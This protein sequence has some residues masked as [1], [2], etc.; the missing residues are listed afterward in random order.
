[1]RKEDWTLLEDCSEW[2]ALGR[3]SKA[4]YRFRKTNY[5]LH[6][7]VFDSSILIEKKDPFPWV[8]TI[9][10]MLNSDSLSNE[11]KE[12]AAYYIHLDTDNLSIISTES[13][14]EILNTIHGSI[15]EWE[16]VVK[17]RKEKELLDD[18]LGKVAADRILGQREMR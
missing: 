1:M 13:T 5:Y 16:S 9:E 17:A 7:L 10:Y 12:F 11:D 6:I 2:R 4:I 18:I 15:E 14:K 8:T 3:H